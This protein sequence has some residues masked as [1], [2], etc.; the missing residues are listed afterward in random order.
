MKKIEIGDK[1]DQFKIIS[2]LHAGAM[3][4]IFK[5]ELIDGNTPFPLVMK[6]PKTSLSDGG[7]NIISF[8]VEQ[9]IMPN[10]TG[11]HVPKF[12]SAS[13]LGQ[14]PYI[15]MEHIL[16]QSLE[17][18]IQS[19]KLNEKE[20]FDYA[21]LIATAIHSLHL[22][23]VCHLDLK[24]ANIIFTGEKVVLI[25]FGLSFHAHYPDLLAEEMRK[26]VGS[27]AYMA[28][29]QVVGVRGDPR[30]DIF[31][32][33]VILYELATGILP[34]GNPSTV[35]GLRKRLWVDPTPP[36]KLN[37]LISEN[38]QEVILKCLQVEA[39]DRYPSMAHLILDLKNFDQIKI[40]DLGKKI[41]G[42]NWKTHFWR[43]LKS[44]GKEYK[45][46]PLP[47][48]TIQEVPIILVA[49]PFQDVKEHTLISL[50]D[51][52]KRSLGI[53]PGARLTCLRIIPPID[54]LKGQNES[55]IFQNH[56]LQLQKWSKPIESNL[57]QISHHVLESTDVAEAI[58]TYAKSNHVSMI[59]LGA[60]THGLKLQKIIATVPIKVAMEAPCT[61][62][63]VKEHQ[64]FE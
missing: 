21:A 28:P 34:F 23:N 42:T 57:H 52:V 50:R 59:I 40:T 46:S 64:A 22:Q 36:R 49:V 48:K 43:F 51:A 29:E 12:F 13:G 61:T 33:G 37:S 25:D 55:E 1:L 31:S 39:E 6:V 2:K 4:S 54:H 5:V 11:G 32:L 20:I 10:L 44:A 58:L 27:F 60:A 15:V 63:L 56:L 62:I 47:L 16:G 3:A 53:R 45:P 30:S 8:E 14:T 9:M 17:D 7:E 26:A 35:D 19:K 24:P 38:L 41:K 18:I